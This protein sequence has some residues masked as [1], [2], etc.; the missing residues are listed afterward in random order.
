MPGFE[1]QTIGLPRINGK[2]TSPYAGEGMQPGGRDGLNYGQAICGSE[3]C[4]TAP[5]NPGTLGTPETVC[6]LLALTRRFELPILI[7]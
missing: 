5:N 3:L 2:L 4:Q 1:D 6:V 7:V